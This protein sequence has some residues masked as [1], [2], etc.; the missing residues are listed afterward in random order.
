MAW[1][2]RKGRGKVE[3]DYEDDDEDDVL[4]QLSSGSLRVD[5][6]VSQ[7]ESRIFVGTWNV[8]GRSPAG[9]LAAELDEWLNLKD[10]A[11]MYVLGFPEIVPMKTKNMIRGEDLTE[12]SNWNML[13][14]KAL[15]ER[16]RC[17][18]STPMVHPI[19]D[20]SY[21][22]KDSSTNE[23]QKGGTSN[24][25]SATEENSDSSMVLDGLHR[26]KLLVSE[27]MVGVFITAWIRTELLL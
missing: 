27:K 23:R 20:E 9:S 4:R 15:N 13:I 24:I 17:P 18:W 26:Y 22:H 2:N 14:G 21:R 12:A 3:G 1:I 10:A 5:P 19:S 11:D 6:Y 25:I 7:N 8:A 16:Y